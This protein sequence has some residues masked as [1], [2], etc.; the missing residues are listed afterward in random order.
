MVVILHHC[1]KN[2][3]Q[4]STIPVGVVLY[5][6]APH[7]VNHSSMSHRPGGIL[8]FLSHLWIIYVGIGLLIVTVIVAAIVV[9]P[10]VYMTALLDDNNL[11]LW[12]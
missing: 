6:H 7:S 2:T 10:A 3:T 12:L 8:D 4:Y 9:T 1:C 11:R 5:H